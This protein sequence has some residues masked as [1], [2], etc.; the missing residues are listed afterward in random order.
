MTHNS[1]FEQYDF[2]TPEEI[3][4]LEQSRRVGRYADYKA[5]EEPDYEIY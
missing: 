2:A 1:G 5:P 4:Q 3:R